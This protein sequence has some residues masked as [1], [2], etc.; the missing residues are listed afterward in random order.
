VAQGVRAEEKIGEE[1]AR[2]GISLL[3]S[4]RSVGL[5]GSPSH[6]PYCFVEIPIDGDIPISRQAPR[7]FLVARRVGE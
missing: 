7:K 1:A 3:A 4:P 6:P 5:K 2:T